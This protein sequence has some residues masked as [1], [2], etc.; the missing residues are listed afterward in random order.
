MTPD[1]DGRGGL[2]SDFAFVV[3]VLAILAALLAL[4]GQP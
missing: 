1:D 3:T 4:I 2:W